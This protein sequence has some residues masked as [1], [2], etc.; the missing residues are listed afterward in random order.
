MICEKCNKNQA[1][2]HIVKVINGIK[3]ETNICEK[4]AKDYEG[5]NLGSSINLD[6]PFS[7]QNLLGGLVEY[8]TEDSENNRSLEQSCNN[9][10]MTYK[11]F[12]QKGLLGCSE[13]YRTFSKMVMPVVKRVQGDIEHIGKVPE[14][15]G[16]EI[17]EKQRL[18]KLKEELQKAILSEEYEKAAMLRDEIKAL[19]KSE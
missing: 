8:I 7:F 3:Q 6:S 10:G 19:Q 12:K 18:L 15:S 11:E 1:T 5:F 4:C 16:K 14:K 9:C 17:V 13:C 2:V